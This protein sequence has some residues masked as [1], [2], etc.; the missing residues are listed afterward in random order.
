MRC[1][2]MRDLAPDVALNTLSADERSEALRHLATCAECRRLVD[3]L[4][5][6][7]DE[8]FTL[9]PAQEPPAGFESRTLERM[10]LAGAP[11]RRRRWRTWG[12]RIAA[13]VAAAAAAASVMVA[14]YHDDHQ[15]ASRYRGTLEE[16]NGKYFSAGRLR[17]PAGAR[18][19]TAFA[20]QGKPSWVFVVVDRAH[21]HQAATGEVVTRDGRSIRLRGFHLRADGTWGGGIPVD[22]HEVASI[23]L[24]GK[25]PGQ[26]LEAP[27]REE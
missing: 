9:A 18:A 24:L 16:A 21:R 23:R 22:V 3:Q 11:R 4:S 6:V 10:G 14:V 7:A 25:Q 5:E 1:E 19:G 27:R 15:L 13:P 2:E 20:Y 26:V 17:D 12:L 8:L